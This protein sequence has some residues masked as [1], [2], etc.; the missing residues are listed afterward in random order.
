MT[1]YLR[2]AMIAAGAA[3]LISVGLGI[4]SGVAFF[5]MIIRAVIF[6]AVFFGLGFA[7]RFIV[8]TY[9]AEIFLSS[10][11]LEQSYAAEKEEAQ[12]SMVIDT[13]GE[14]AVPELYKSPGNPDQLGNIEDLISGFF[15]PRAEG[16]DRMEEDGYN[17]KSARSAVIQR[18]SGVPVQETINFKD[19][20]QDAAVFDEPQGRAHSETVDRPVFTPSLGDE[21]E[22]LGGLPDLDAMAMAFGGSSAPSGTSSSFYSGEEESAPMM[23]DFSE[24]ESPS[25]QHSTGNKA[26]PLSG[27]FNPKDLAEGIRTVLSKEK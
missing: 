19:M 13:M 26:Q 15:K 14:Y 18:S 27:D 4:I 16:V 8:N 9:F 10:N 23:M 24:P 22:G 11:E 2:W 17:G 6:A 21:S 1:L 20:F 25:S 3:F 12:T 7:L 5:H